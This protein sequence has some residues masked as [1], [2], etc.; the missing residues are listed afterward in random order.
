MKVWDTQSLP[1]ADR[2][3]YWREV[4]CEAFTSLDSKAHETPDRRS[5]VTLHE[6]ADVNGVDLSSFSQRISHGL[7][8]IQRYKD[9]FYF[10]NYQIDGRC[11]VEQ[12]G[13]Q[14]CAAPGQFYLVDTTRPY[15]LE[16]MDS[17]H[18]IS[19][20]VPRG[21]L[22]PLIGDPRRMTARVVDEREPLG[23][24]AGTYMRE[25]LRTAPEVPSD[26]RTTLADTLSRLIAL[27]VS[28][29][30]PREAESLG[31]T[32]RAFHDAI[33]RYVCERSADPELSV[34][35]VANRFR[36]S[37][38]TVQSIF[39]ERGGSFTQTLLDRRLEA[40]RNALAERGASITE[41]ALDSGFGDI[42]YFGRAFRQRYGCSPREW[43]HEAAKARAAA[44]AAE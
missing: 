30:A 29:Q 3:A 23:N 25:L 11:G 19:F 31:H 41:I 24:L 39:A 34:G 17:F 15:H 42:S 32:R 5:V 2:F 26:A 37:P 13:R 27:A 36:I 4:L 14:I 40:A 18:T 6:F 38:R 10:V 28:A 16:F 33:Q 44:A 7:P 20:R 12:D 8:E 35:A 22:G 43:R 1:L 9:D 21:Q